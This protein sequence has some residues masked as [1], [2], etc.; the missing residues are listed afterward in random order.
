MPVTQPTL[1]LL[2]LDRL[3]PVYEAGR[4]HFALEL[5]LG[6]D[7]ANLEP[8][9]AALVAPELLQPW[10]WRIGGLDVMGRDGDSEPLA[11]L[12]HIQ[13]GTVPAPADRP[14]D[15]G[16][17]ARAME[18][19]FAELVQAGPRAFVTDL[20]SG[21]VACDV[22]DTTEPGWPE[23][24]ATSLRAPAPIGAALNLVLVFSL[25][26]ALAEAL[27]TVVATPIFELEGDFGFAP[28]GEW[29][30]F[31]DGLLQRRYAV[32]PEPE[33]L[34]LTA[35]TA[36]WTRPDSG[37][38]T[39]A[40]QIDLESLWVRKPTLEGR[41]WLAQLPLTLADAA[42]GSELLFEA[43]ERLGEDLPVFSA[44]ATAWSRRALLT[45]LWDSA[46]PGALADLDPD[47]AQ[48]RPAA[49]L[50]T[51]LL[52]RLAE[53]EPEVA[54]SDDR[55]A[56][57]ADYIEAHQ[58]ANSADEARLSTF[59]GLLGEVL[60]GPAVFLAR[61]TEGE[62]PLHAELERWRGLA[63]RLAEPGARAA[64][65]KAHWRQAF[66][67][68]KL[69]LP[70]AL[71]DGLLDGLELRRRLLLDRLQPVWQAVLDAEAAD[72]HQAVMTAFTDA[73]GGQLT[74]R[75]GTPPLAG[76]EAALETLI[77]A[78]ADAFAPD[79]DEA[80]V[81][82][83]RVAVAAT[84][85]LVIQV[86]A[87]TGADQAELDR[88]LA[89][90]GVLIRQRDGAD[91][92]GPWHC[93]TMGAVLVRTEETDEGAAPVLDLALAPWP[94]TEQQGLRSTALAYDNHPLTATSL[95]H[96]LATDLDLEPVGPSDGKLRLA[97]VEQVTAPDLAATWRRLVGLKF[98]QT[99]EIACF[100]V[101]GSGALPAVLAEPGQPLTMR[102]PGSLDDRAVPDFARQTVTYRRR[103]RI[104]APR[105][106][107]VDGSAGGP[108]R[109]PSF[110]VDQIQPVAFERAQAL[111]QS[112]LPAAELLG[113]LVLLRPPG[114]G[115]AAA[116][117]REDHPAGFRLGV[118]PPAIDDDGFDRW[119]AFEGFKAG[120][121][122]DEGRRLAETRAVV[123]A[124]LART[125]P[126]PGT[127][128]ER[129]REQDQDRSLDDPAVTAI[130][131][132][133]EALRSDPG[134]VALRL[135]P[136]TE[137]VLTLPPPLQGGFA[138]AQ[139]PAVPLTIEAVATGEPVLAETADGGCR[140]TVPERQVCRLVIA[141][142]VPGAF[143]KDGSDPRLAV[144]AP[145]D[146]SSDGL[147]AVGES[148]LSIEVATAELPTAEALFAAIRPLPRSGETLEVGVVPGDPAFAWLSRV[149]LDRQL[150]SWRGRQL[151]GHFP[152]AS[153]F[154]GMPAS[155]LLAL[156]PSSVD[157]D[158]DPWQAVRHWDGYG[159]ADREDFDVVGETGML[160]AGIPDAKPLKLHTIDL[161][162]DDRALYFRYRLTATS[163]YLGL[164]A[165]PRSATVRSAGRHDPWKR[166][167]VRCRRV[168]PLPPP[169]LRF[170]LPLTL[171]LKEA[172]AVP[173][174]APLLLLLHE[175]WTATAGLVERLRPRI[176]GH[177][178]ADPA[179]WPQ[180]GYDPI[181]STATILDDD[182]DDSGGA[183]PGR[184]VPLLDCDAPPFGLTFDPG[185][186]GLPVTSC[187]V[188]GLREQLPGRIRPGA[189]LDLRLRHE[190]DPAGVVDGQTLTSPE[191]EPE[192]VALPAN[193]DRFLIRFA[194]E[195]AAKLR[196]A[197]RSLALDAAG[198]LI[199]RM[200]HAAV[201]ALG[202]EPGEEDSKR[203]LAVWRLETTRVVNAAGRRDTEVF[204]DL[205]PLDL[206]REQ[207]VSSGR[208]VR[209]VVLEQHEQ[210]CDHD[211][212]TNQEE[213]FA[214]LFPEDDDGRPVDSR[215]RIVALSPP[216]EATGRDLEPAGAGSPMP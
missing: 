214:H 162:G 48:R 64:V 86:D 160:V 52:E 134:T 42:E 144:T 195:A 204:H 73:L 129:S 60:G 104:G 97:T 126:T 127:S 21:E 9:A 110:D 24:V 154:A 67:E 119:L 33:G 30:P 23:L 125:A 38:T 81:D 145:A 135:A 27:E 7:P 25:E 5:A 165:D 184:A 153:A 101:L 22:G 62:V 61:T 76:L 99:Y 65:L 159:F 207:P 112:E 122:S 69:E 3:G 41:D 55:A 46:H 20:R 18:T 211:P 15:H 106:V 68:A 56:A 132:R 185:P 158:T 170:V 53:A 128:E 200:T 167:V 213:L 1:L 215:G 102:D 186:V 85:P 199:C 31:A 36:G 105:L 121:E 103:T 4:T 183:E 59:A 34:T 208:V 45:L 114:S 84:Q 116:P 151:L 108:L 39:G 171:P 124:H 35:V 44:E 140:I 163:R 40:S 11:P 51:E 205:H 187:Y 80:E 54:A 8:D 113:P 19:R 198:R 78:R 89:G 190:A 47:A 212:P 120:E 49:P 157:P 91:G 71:L 43:I 79:A 130:R 115:E 98:G 142:L 202:L 131:L 143:F 32:T 136:I 194:G 189:M 155:E 16:R 63:N 182:N 13:L 28:E 88:R 58:P 2:T 37:G 169:R 70:Q 164:F 197:S 118:R 133:L 66:A 196:A 174:T 177:D 149:R 203:R 117:W 172:D 50:A 176:D 72:Q 152:F 74:A 175:T 210:H 147:C 206:D 150:W 173:A 95:K 29:R 90:I 201:A 82:P 17:Y 94:I 179:H 178:P 83:D 123:M 10:R 75:L 156:E 137:L 161:A 168:A 148:W 93:L 87:A 96:R 141:S 180:Y 57:L 138:L 12:A 100:A 6:L 192:W 139:R 209:L 188:L 146:R 77:E 109:P 26:Q 181:D 92:W 166:L 14:V 193:A 107:P 216:I 111:E 191:T